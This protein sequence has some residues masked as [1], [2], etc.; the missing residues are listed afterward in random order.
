MLSELGSTSQMGVASG[1]GGKDVRS[2]PQFFRFLV[3][4]IFVEVWGRVLQ[5]K[6]EEESNGCSS[7]FLT[8]DRLVTVR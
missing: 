3:F 4:S 7:V 6:I 1:K 5:A 2:R 8:S